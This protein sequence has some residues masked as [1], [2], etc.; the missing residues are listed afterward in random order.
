MKNMFHFLQLW[1]IVLCCTP[2]LTLLS[3]VPMINFIVFRCAFSLTL[4]WPLI[5]YFGSLNE[6][7]VLLH[8]QI[9]KYYFL[10]LGH[11]CFT[12]HWLKG[13]QIL[14]KFLKSIFFRGFPCPCP[15]SKVSC[16]LWSFSWN[17]HL[18]PHSVYQ[19]LCW[20]SF[21]TMMINFI[22]QSFVCSSLFKKLIS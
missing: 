20:K 11:L 17:L 10:C 18:F 12:L 7:K 22:S 9:L 6:P 14:V 5:Y 4:Y 3:L 21:F 16:P 13:T 1:C 19:N 8:P 2:S 15:R